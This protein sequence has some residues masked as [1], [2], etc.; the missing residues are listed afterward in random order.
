MQG[1]EDVEV[2]GDLLRVADSLERTS[3]SLV[4]A[5]EYLAESR[6]SHLGLSGQTRAL[7]RGRQQFQWELAALRAP[8]EGVPPA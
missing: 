1:T 5:Q 8:S 6:K 4:S 3:A 2:R 7:A